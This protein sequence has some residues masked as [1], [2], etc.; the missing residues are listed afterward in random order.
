MTKMFSGLSDEGLEETTDRIGGFQAKESGLYT[1]PIKAAYAGE[2]QSGAKN[3]TVVLD[4]DGS[5]YEETIYYTNKKGE[6]FFLNKQDKT[7]KVPLPGYTTINDM[8]L[9]TT[10]EPLSE[11]ET[12]EKTMNIYDYD[13]KK[14]LPTSVQ[15]I[16]GL[17]GEVVTVGIVK[18]LE[19]KAKKN[20]N[21][22]YVDTA[23]TREVN[24]IDKVFHTESSMTVVEARDG[25]EEAA[26]MEAWNDR[27]SGQTRDKRTIKD[28][29][30]GTDGAPKSGGSTGDKAPKKS[31][32]NKG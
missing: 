15:M 27:N 1:G 19:N 3:V 6:N 11:Q 20:G 28:G 18:T 16:T 7:K 10:G 25:A 4:L 12:E 13:A 24:N 30:G 23:E 5:D 32:F 9:V 26:F 29:E 8:C 21:G 14:E 17:I 22:E 2:A 31:L